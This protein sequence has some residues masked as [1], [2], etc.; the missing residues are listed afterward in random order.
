MNELSLVQVN[1][2][3][4]PILAMVVITAEQFSLSGPLQLRGFGRA[5]GMTQH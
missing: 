1:Y 3:C 5:S 4:A 2:S